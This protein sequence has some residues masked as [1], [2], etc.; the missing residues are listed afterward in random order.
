MISHW[1]RLT[2]AAKPASTC[3][4]ASLPRARRRL[5]QLLIA[6]AF[7]ASQA[8]PK[9]LQR[10]VRLPDALRCRQPSSASVL[11]RL[12]APL[13]LAVRYGLLVC[14]QSHVLITMPIT[15]SEPLKAELAHLR[16]DVVA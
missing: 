12:H 2:S 9:V 14:R 16:Q 6:G 13:T 15:V 5:H 3:P 4:I 1:A 8:E 7:D 11:G 10:S